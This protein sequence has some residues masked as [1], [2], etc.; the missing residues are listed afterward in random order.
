MASYTMTMQSSGTEN[1][2][3]IGSFARAKS[4]KVSVMYR[5]DEILIAK[6][7]RS[8]LVARDCSDIQKAV[9]PQAPLTVMALKDERSSWGTYSFVIY[10]AGWVSRLFALAKRYT[11]SPNA[12]SSLNESLM[13]IK[14]VGSIMPAIMDQSG[15]ADYDIVAVSAPREFSSGVRDLYAICWTTPPFAFA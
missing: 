11:T 5:S 3:P 7:E 2:M 13:K 8:T 10:R 4:I 12:E 14:A 1:R 15:L 6:I 9:L